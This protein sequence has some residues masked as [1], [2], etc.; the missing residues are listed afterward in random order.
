[1]SLVLDIVLNAFAKEK[2]LPKDRLMSEAPL[3]LDL[4]AT[5]FGEFQCKSFQYLMP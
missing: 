2:D 4:E 1:M 3:T 5:Y